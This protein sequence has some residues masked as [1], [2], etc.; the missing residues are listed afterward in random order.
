METIV[1]LE[2]T[3]ISKKEKTAV[4]AAV[5]C[6]GGA[7]VSNADACCQLDEEKKEQGEDGCGCNANAVAPI[8]AKSSCC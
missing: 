4:P 2:K 1:A 5:G 7:P 6:C 8:Q 3:T